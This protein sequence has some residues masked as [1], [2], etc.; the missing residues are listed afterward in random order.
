MVVQQLD[1]SF[2][3][4]RLQQGA[5]LASRCG[6]G[7]TYKAVLPNM[8]TGLHLGGCSFQAGFG[9]Y[10]LVPGS[11]LT[12]TCVAFGYLCADEQSLS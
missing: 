8:V 12:L 4:Q 10:K 1:L 9:C 7:D 2:L 6:E 3:R 5:H 11:L